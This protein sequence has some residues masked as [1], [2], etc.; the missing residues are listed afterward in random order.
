MANDAAARKELQRAVAL[1]NEGRLA[2]AELIVAELESRHPNDV[3]VAHFGGVLA[4]R[5]GRFDIAVQRLGRAVRA[6]PRR[7]KAHAALAFA[8]EQSGRMTEARDAYAAAI[9]ADPRFAQAHN[10]IGVVLVKMGAP[11]AALPHFDRAAALDAASVE[12]RLNAA[13][14]LLDMGRDD[15]AATKFRDGARL[16]RTDEALQ[17]SAEGLS[18][19]G[20]FDSAA[21]IYATL[22]SRHAADSS[23]RARWAL[24]L[25]G[26]GRTDEAM[27]QAQS[28]VAVAPSAVAFDAYSA[29]LLNH[30]RIDE[31]IEAARRALELDAELHEAAFN[32]ASALR[33]AGRGDEARATLDALEPRLDAVGLASLA[34]RHADLGDSAKCIACCERAIARDPSISAAHCTLAIELLRTGELDRGWREYAYRPWRGSEILAQVAAGSYPPRWPGSV[35]G[36]DIVIL[37]EQGLGDMLFFL[38]FAP[39]LANAGARLHAMHLD[40]R[41]LPIVKRSLAIEAWPADRGIPGDAIAIWAGDLPA[42]VQALDVPGDPAALALSALPDRV[43]RMSQRLGEGHRPRIAVAWQAGARPAKRSLRQQFLW[44]EITPGVL[45]EAL[46]G[47]S[48]DW[49]SVQRNPEEGATARFEQAVGARVAD[50]S[51]ANADLEDMLALLSIVD[52]Y[53]GMSSTNI[54]LL[55]GLGRQAHVLVPFPPDWRWQARGRSA[56]FPRFEVLRQ[57]PA[58]EWGEALRAL[59]AALV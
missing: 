38:R 7:A 34:V 15:E 14:A 33:S 49:I 20:D 24:A 56:W 59:R 29:L 55:A 21:T 46:S 19:A 35:A 44:K 40:A 25:E 2:T 3:E 39:A 22:L 23:L 10:G 26:A 43:E 5:M 12:P 30:G 41:L 54:H 13:R 1:F 28:A 31:A 53:A 52:G 45:G 6:D 51:D 32:L 36:R 50:L 37:A 58:L 9:A 18:Q 57:S 16:A 47:L 42:F 11:A 17:A 8:L 27:A 48:V 4:N